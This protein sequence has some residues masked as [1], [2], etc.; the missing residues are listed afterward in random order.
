M[1]VIIVFAGKRFVAGSTMPVRIWHYSQNTMVDKRPF[2][3]QVAVVSVGSFCLVSNV[4]YLA[5][6]FGI[7]NIRQFI[8]ERSIDRK[9]HPV[10][11][12]AMGRVIE[13]CAVS[14]VARS[15]IKIGIIPV[16]ESLKHF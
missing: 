5:V 2:M 14:L 12:F 8:V 15:A 11:G 16:G 10:S 9:P 1:L 4:T 7:T 3:R 6:E 13:P